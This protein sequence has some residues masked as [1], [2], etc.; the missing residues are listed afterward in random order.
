[1]HGLVDAAARPRRD[2]ARR[3]AVVERNTT[4]LPAQW[5]LFLTGLIEPRSTCCRSASV[6]AASSGRCRAR[7]ASRSTYKT[8]V[9]PGLMAAAAMNGAVLDTTFNFFFKFKYAHTYDAML[10]TPL[11]VRDVAYGEMTWALLRGARLLGRVPRD[12][13]G[14]RAGAF[15]VG[16]ARGAGRR[17]SSRPR[18]RARASRHDLHAIVDRL[19]LREPRAHPDVPVLG[20]VLPAVAVPGRGAGGRAVTP[21][22][23]GVVLERALVLGHVEW[24]ILLNVLYL[25]VM[26]WL[27]V[28][29]AT[30]R[31]RRPAPALVRPDRTGVAK[32]HAMRWLAD[33]GTS[34]FASLCE[35]QRPVECHVRSGR[36]PPWRPNGPPDA[37]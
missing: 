25:V 2:R 17:C 4:R 6:S 10:A 24:T 22:Y 18:S 12:D 28:R 16:A 3:C 35:H 11:G 30:R 1:M 19:R 8:F 14:R 33:A 37:T 15:V 13:G 21:L 26:A 27:G 36:L 29:I 9:A 5:Y 32:R 34:R 23:Q 7:E 20:D 31:L